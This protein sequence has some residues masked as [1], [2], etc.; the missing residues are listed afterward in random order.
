M[1][2]HF[3]NFFIK[4]IRLFIEGLSQNKGIRFNECDYIR[5]NRFSM[6]YIIELLICFLIIVSIRHIPCLYI[7]Y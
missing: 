5:L 7:L 6:N 3:L 4:N 2:E 1:L